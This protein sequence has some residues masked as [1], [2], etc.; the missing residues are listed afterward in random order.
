MSSP[1]PPAK[2]LRTS[3][4]ALEGHIH[5]PLP[6]FDMDEIYD[7]TLV[8]IIVGNEKSGIKTFTVPREQVCA[9]SNYLAGALKRDFKE[10]KEKTVKLEEFNPR[11]FAIFLT[12]INTCKIALSWPSTGM[13]SFN[14]YE[15]TTWGFE[16][17]FDCYFL[18]DYIGARGFRQRIFE[19]I[20][21]KFIDHGRMP[22]GAEIREAYEKTPENSQLRRLIVDTAVSRDV[23]SSD[24]VRL[25]GDEHPPMKFVAEM[26]LR[27]SKHISA[28]TCYHCSPHTPCDHECESK[29]HTRE[30]AISDGVL[31]WCNYH[32]HDT[33]EEKELC[34]WRAKAVQ[35]RIAQEARDYRGE[36]YEDD[37][38]L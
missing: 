35:E 9:H 5:D 1:T 10:S 26:Q 25:Y 30:D 29:K 12:F 24:P 15:P 7:T 38:D 16:M 14:P 18:G 23:P 21:I 28:L 19:T 34:K 36:D 33:E 2:K 3:T 27:A 6:K 31:M 11:S 20:Q 32:E 22:S 37:E 17:L 4:A 8:K 13:T